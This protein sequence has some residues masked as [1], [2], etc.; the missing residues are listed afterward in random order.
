MIINDT[1]GDDNYQIHD[2]QPNTSHNLLMHQDDNQFHQYQMRMTITQI[3]NMSKYSNMTY[4]FF[5]FFIQFQRYQF[6]FTS[7][8]IHAMFYIVHTP[9]FVPIV[10]FY[11]HLS[12]DTILNKTLTY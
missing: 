8:K 7:I 2:C 11:I 12:Y 9:L 6:F 5:S 4:I 3:P 10:H 1:N